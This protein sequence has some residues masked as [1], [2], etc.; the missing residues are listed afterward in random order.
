[1]VVA[2][3]LGVSTVLQQSADTHTKVETSTRQSTW[4]AMTDTPD[5]TTNPIA[6]VQTRVS[7]NLHVPQEDRGRRIVHEPSGT[8]L[9]NGRRFEPT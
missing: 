6:A 4:R 7:G 5:P 8:E 9:V 1:M 2:K 3:P